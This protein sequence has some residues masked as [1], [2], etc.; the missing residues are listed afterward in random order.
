MEHEKR[1][2]VLIGTMIAQIGLGTL[3]TWSMFN[4]PL[5]HLHHWSI[6]QVA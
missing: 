6:E 2:F 4:K 1:Y 5:G 3:Y